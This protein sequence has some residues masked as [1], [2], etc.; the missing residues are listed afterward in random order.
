MASGHLIYLF[1]SCVSVDGT[2]STS[3]Q[4]IICTTFLEERRTPVGT[5]MPE[6]TAMTPVGTV[7]KMFQ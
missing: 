7:W 1:S 2:R 6:D 4:L 3:S 5:A